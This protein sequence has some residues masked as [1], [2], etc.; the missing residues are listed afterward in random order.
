MPAGF[1]LMSTPPRTRIQDASNHLRLT[2]QIGLPLLERHV[3]VTVQVKILEA[4]DRRHG[5]VRVRR[6][7]LADVVVELMDQN[8]TKHREASG[9]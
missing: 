8:G 1:A 5:D 2:I 4:G 9:P 6:E 7:V 3:A